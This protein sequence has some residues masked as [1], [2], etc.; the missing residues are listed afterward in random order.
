MTN[1][2]NNSVGDSTNRKEHHQQNLKHYQQSKALALLIS[3]LMVRY[4][5]HGR[6]DP[7]TDEQLAPRTAAI[8]D[9]GDQNRYF[10]PNQEVF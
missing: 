10:K 1:K 8:R 6:M 9:P 2:Q 5:V 4:P 7:A 3:E